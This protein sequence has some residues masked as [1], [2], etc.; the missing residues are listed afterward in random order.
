MASLVFQFLSHRVL[1]WS[2]AP[3]SLF[4][5]FPLNFLLINNGLIYL[6]LFYAQVLFYGCALLG[7]ILQSRENQNKTFFHSLLLLDDEFMRSSGDFFATSLAHSQLYGKRPR[8][9]KAANYRTL[10]TTVDFY[11]KNKLVPLLGDFSVVDVESIV[12]KKTD[13]RH[14]CVACLIQLLNWMELQQRQTHL[15]QQQRLFEPTQ[16][17]LFH[18]PITQIHSRERYILLRLRRSPYQQHCACRCLPERTKCYFY[19]RLR[20]QHEYLQYA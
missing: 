17:L 2:L 16:I 9:Q 15:N 12:S 13:Q 3:I 14:V 6:G 8:E 20:Q 1:R 19:Y 11:E 4:A 5:I 7:Y 18:L 10:S